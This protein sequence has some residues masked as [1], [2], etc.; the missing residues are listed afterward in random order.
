MELHTLHRRA[1]WPSLRDLSRALGRG[2]ASS[3]RIGDAFTQPRLPAWGLLDVLVAELAG[4][5]PRADPTAEIERFHALWEAAA[6]AS[7]APTGPADPPEEK[8][9]PLDPPRSAPPATPSA[10]EMEWSGLASYIAEMKLAGAADEEIQERLREMGILSEER[11]VGHLPEDESARVLQLRGPDSGPTPAYWVPKPG[12]PVEPSEAGDLASSVAWI[13]R[14]RNA[15]TPG[16]IRHMFR[17][18]MRRVHDLVKH[19]EARLVDTLTD[20]R[21]STWER[22]ETR[23]QINR[24]HAWSKRADQLNDAFHLRASLDDDDAL[25]R[26][27]LQE[28]PNLAYGVAALKTLPPDRGFIEEP[29]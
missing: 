9:A 3:S 4:R 24:L 27:L 29:Q 6:E 5:I 22:E 10:D 7:T 16:E 12:A 21:A 2:V 14:R 13:L 18:T 11:P 15:M 1:G 26:L 19:K 28:V 17:R 8:D 25:H 20:D 23:T